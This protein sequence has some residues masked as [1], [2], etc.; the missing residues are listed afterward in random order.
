M[1]W[2]QAYDI[3][4]HQNN[5]YFLS[6][7]VHHTFLRQYIKFGRKLLYD[8]YATYPRNSLEAQSHTKEYELAGM[9]GTIASMDV[10][11][12]ATENNLIG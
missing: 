2:W 8:K 3:H 4:S 11:H 10:C 9:Y 6:V 12:V 1:Y 5:P 7:E